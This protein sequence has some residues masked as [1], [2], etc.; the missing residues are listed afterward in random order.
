MSHPA[1]A[2]G[3]ES[4]PWGLPR[5]PTLLPSST[6][7]PHLCGSPTWGA[8]CSAI[9]ARGRLPSWRSL[10]TLVNEI[11]IRADSGGVGGHSSTSAKAAKFFVFLGAVGMARVKNVSSKRLGGHAFLSGSWETPRHRPN[12]SWHPFECK[13]PICFGQWWCPHVRTAPRQAR[14]A[15]GHAAWGNQGVEQV[16]KRR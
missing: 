8:T 2:Q 14:V 11:L 4:S 7:F 6:T 1:N 10:Q 13:Q 15:K 9:N 12:F 3:F 16:W 5:S